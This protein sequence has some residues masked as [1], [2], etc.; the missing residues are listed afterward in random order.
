MKKAPIPAN[1]EQRLAALRALGI[2]DTPPEERFDRITR[3]AKRVFG[4]PIARH[5]EAEIDADAQNAVRC[6][7]AMLGELEG[8]NAVWRS[9]GLPSVVIR[10][11]IYTGKL[12][13]GVD[14][15]AVHG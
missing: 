9:E 4:V 3:L 1:E 14:K 5:D 12:L 2:L 6:A 7:S 13:A 8:L 10:V 15:V 11:G